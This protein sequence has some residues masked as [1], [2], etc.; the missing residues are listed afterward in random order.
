MQNKNYLIVINP[1]TGNKGQRYLNQ[2][3]S[4]LLKKDLSYDSFSN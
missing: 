4:A 1:Q 3:I 2:L